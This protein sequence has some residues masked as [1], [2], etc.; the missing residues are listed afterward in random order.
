MNHRHRPLL[1]YGRRVTA[2][3]W[4]AL[5]GF[6]VTLSLAIPAQAYPWM[7]RHD[8][9]GCMPC[10]ADPSGAGLLTQYG[11][12]QADVVLITHYT[13]REAEEPSPTAQFLW[14]VPLPEWLLLG[15][16]AREMVMYSRGAGSEG[17]TRFVHMVS[18]LRAQVAQ[19]RWRA[20]G[21][22]GYSH[23]G[24][25]PAAIT[26]R[27]E[28][29]L[30][31]REH[32]LGYELNPERGWLLRAG[33]LN[34]PFGIRS[35]EHTLFPRA[36]TRTSIDADQQ[37]GVALAWSGDTY[38]AEAMAV[39]GNYQLRPDRFRE[40]GYSIYLEKTFAP[41]LAVGLSSLATY[42]KED[43]DLGASAI[44][45]A[46]GPFI[47]YGPWK[48]LVV[49]LEVDA[50]PR[51]P[52]EGK[53]TTGVTS[54]L[55]LDVEPVQGLHGVL[56]GELG[57]PGPTAGTSL[58]GWASLVWFFLPHADLRLDAIRQRRAV[59]AEQFGFTTLLAQLHVYL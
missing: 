12:A 5:A 45:S 31:S 32:W 15:G 51:F 27:T 41:R 9:T 24:A 35:V 50:L 34:L 55:Q 33:R 3:L 20:A 43:L 8:Y 54:Y 36:M 13:K 17:D 18:E 19:K 37:H 29:N 4:L 40:R 49:L 28:H 11:R 26:R 22:L 14:G 1:G 56:T 10:H 52:L 44:R 6:A 2:G 46:H 47:R 23:Q 39:L 42:A 59:A 48:P 38:R 53:A 25:R 7:I 16:S 21:S 58:G 57:D 30:V